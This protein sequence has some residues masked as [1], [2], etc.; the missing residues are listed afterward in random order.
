MNLTELQQ[1]IIATAYDFNISGL[2]VGTSGNLSARHEDGFLITPTGV[3][4]SDLRPEDIVL[5]DLHGRVVSGVLRPSSEWPLHA[6]IYTEREDVN[7][8]V[9][10]HSPYATGLACNRKAIPA[11]HYMVAVAAGDQIPCAE[12]ATF[13]TDE[14][15]N[16]VVSVL[17]D[18]KACLLA[19]HGMVAVGDTVASAYKLAHEVELLAKQYCISLQ[20]GEPVL[21][22]AAEMQTNIEKF[23]MYGKQ[24]N[25]E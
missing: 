11:F 19:N 7:A 20:F 14:L 24:D 1:E 16:N 6:A 5:C 23:K 2:S 22:D 18:Y 4:Y 10:V 21:L 9:H 17:S 12:Y 13:G 25:Q 8:I 15:S 3:A